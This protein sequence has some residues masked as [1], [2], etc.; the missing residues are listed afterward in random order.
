[1]DQNR[2]PV[3]SVADP[4]RAG[5]AGPDRR[6]AR[7]RGSVCPA[8]RDRR[9]PCQGRHPGR[10]RLAAHRRAVRRAGADRAV[11]VVELNRASRWAGHSGR[12]PGWRSSDRCWT[13]RPCATITCSRRWRGTC[14]S[15]AGSSTV[16]PAICSSAPRRSPPTSKTAPPCSSAPPSAPRVTPTDRSVRGT[17]R[18]PGRGTAPGRSGGGHRTLYPRACQKEFG[19]GLSST[20]SS[21]LLAARVLR[22]RR[23]STCVW[24]ALPAP[25]AASTAICWPLLMASPMSTLSFGLVCR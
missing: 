3:G 1:M 9:L 15:R 20:G 11:P 12:R 22:P 4:A 21:T 19:F 23:I 7:H 25:R 10:H 5:A 2:S 6:S 16:Q 14:S 24:L 17:H 13:I 18:G 8:G